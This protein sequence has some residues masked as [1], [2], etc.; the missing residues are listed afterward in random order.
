MMSRTIVGVLRGGTSNEYELSLKTGAAMLNAL[1]DDNYN[2]RDIFIDKRGYWHSRGRPVEPARVLSQI[3]VVLN[4]LHG[5]AGEDGTISR[6]LRSAGIPFAGSDARASALSLNKIR[7]REAF[8]DAAILTPHSVGF[9]LGNGMNTREMAERVFAEFG[10]PYMVKPASDGASHGI[11]VALTVLEL[12][13]VLGDI[14]DAYG[15]ALVEE[16]IRGQEATVGIIEGFRGEELYALPP[17]RISYPSDARHILHDHHHAGLL[18]YNVPSDFSHVEK[19]M[20]IEAARKAHRALELDDFSRSDFIMTPR[21][22]YLLEVNA[23]PGLYDGAAM[24]PMLESVGCS[25]PDYLA[26][27]IELARR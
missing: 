21:G 9:T 15:A 7:A 24:P 8:T 27:T 14:L 1:P 22:P 19:G 23:L 3:D 4:G 18:Q 10:P 2:V 20:L 26:H 6:L 13:D 5:G 12:P 17:A 25:V 11:Q 16:F